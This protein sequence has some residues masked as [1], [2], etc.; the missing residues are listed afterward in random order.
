MFTVAVNGSYPRLLEPPRPQLLMQAIEKHKLGRITDKELARAKDRATIDAVAEMVAA[1]VEMVSDGQIRWNNFTVQLCRELEG[2]TTREDDAESNN[3]NIKPRAI[4]RIKW[5]HPILLDN[6]QFLANRSPVDVRPVITGPFTLAHSC[7]SGIY[8]D[9]IGSLTRDL[10]RA[11]NRELLGLENAGFKYILV[12]EPLLL[13]FKDKIRE[14]TDIAQM[15]LDS[16]KTTVMLGTSGGNILSIETELGNTSFGGFALDLL[17]GPEN[18]RILTHTELWSEKILQFG[19]VHS[20]NKNIERPTFIYR[21][22]VDLARF[23]NPENIWVA[24]TAG[25]GS[26]PRDTAFAK[27]KSLY[28]GACRARRE[29]A[30][31]EEPGGSLPEDGDLN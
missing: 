28:A 14:F 13:T 2:F 18:E 16:L 29:I 10:A 5:S 31:L 1:G 8:G 21:T 4:A 20:F 22:L 25:L 24:P 19:L 11:L 23:H 9:D 6:Y 12:E 27:L 7:D 30:R 26:L 15:L 3:G 17:E